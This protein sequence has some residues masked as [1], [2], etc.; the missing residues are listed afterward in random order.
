MDVPETKYAKSGDL[1]IA[2][3]IF[4]S[5]PVTVTV[6]PLISSVELVWEQELCR[7]ALEYCA[8]HVTMV[9]F[10]KR[11]IGSSDRFEREPTLEERI[12][13]IRAV[14]DAEGIDRANLIGL[15][16][17]GL[18][19]QLFAAYHPERVERLELVNS[20][21]GLKCDPP[22]DREFMDRTFTKWREIQETWGTHPDL[23]VDFV[24]PSQIENHEFVRWVGRWQRFS[25]SPHDFA[26]QL[27]SVVRLRAPSDLTA[28]TAPTLVVQISGDRVIEPENGRILAG[29]IPGAEYREFEGEDHFYWVMP[30]WREIFDVGIEFV[31][32]GPVVSRRERRFAA[33]LFTDVVDST[34]R[35][36][37]A[38]DDRW[39]ETLESHERLCTNAVAHHRG[40]I[41]KST[42][43]GILAT[44]D[45][46]SAAVSA[47][48]RLIKE[49]R[50][51]GLPIRAGVHA[52][53]IEIHAT[54]DISGVAVNVAQR[55]E[56]SADDGTLWVSAAVRDML[57]GGELHF[58][59]RGERTLKGMDGAWRL[60]ALDSG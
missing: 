15:S 35:S 22:M 18:M 27:S 16:E 33:I 45:S 60:Y 52:G 49:L 29:Q 59:D 57:L 53:E 17:G 21:R 32:G 11:G 4:G 20:L 34:V 28:I 8:Q 24:M 38:G 25:A 1:H 50:S 46:P 55:V 26:R 10:D 23:L 58:S 9:Q 43:D 19:A 51:I 12:D 39:H 44:F 41:V 3:Q 31:T 37:A 6:P 54:G 13:D 48:S 2:Y 56:A 36:A 47:G 14:M 40:R 5:G 42:G 7:R 30:N